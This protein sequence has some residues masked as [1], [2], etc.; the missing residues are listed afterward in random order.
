[1]KTGAIAIAAITSCT[2]TSNPYVML[3]AGLIAKKAVEKGLTVPD[4]VK[5]SL[6]P[7][8]K[9]VTGYLRD[10]G[11]QPYLDQLGFNIVGYG[12]TTCIGNSGPL[13]PEIEAA[14]AESDLLLTSV[15]SGNR[16]FEGRI[17]PLVKANYLASPTLVVAYALAGT[18]DIDLQKDSLGKDKDGND[19]YLTDIWPSM[20]K[21]MLLLKLQLH[22]NYS[23]KNTKLYSLIMNV[24]MQFKQVMMRFTHLIINQHIFKTH[25]SLKECQKNQEQ[26]THLTVFV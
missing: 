2:N 8:S 7:G 24:G 26:L 3:G 9:V 10:A 25:R 13:A 15:L 16:N 4:Y 21:L 22:L 18:V 5:T 12:C 23:V 20:K 6:A 1:M 11:L 17:H 14:V 19:V